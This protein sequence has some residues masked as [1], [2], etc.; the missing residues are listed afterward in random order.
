MYPGFQ[1]PNPQIYVK[2]QAN[3]YYA[4]VHCTSTSGYSMYEYEY[5]YNKWNEIKKKY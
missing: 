5:E 3:M 2:G 1:Y 4:G